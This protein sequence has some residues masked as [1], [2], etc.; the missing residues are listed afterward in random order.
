MEWEDYHLHEFVIGRRLYSVPDPDDDMYERKVIDESRVPLGQV[1]PRVGTQFAYLYDFGDSWGH[2]LMLEAIL[3]PE[4]DTRNIRRASAAN[5]A[6][7]QKTSAE[8]PAMKN[9]WRSWPIPNTK[10]MTTC[11]SGEVRSIR[12]HSRPPR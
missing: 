9:I 11:F 2:D 7:P 6:R 10:N 8:R 4:T 1:V 12:K 5:A 3:L